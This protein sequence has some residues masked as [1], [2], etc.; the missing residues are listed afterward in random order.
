MYEKN[1]SQSS[2][3][4]QA[5]HFS[6]LSATTNTLNSRGSSGAPLNFELVAGLLDFFSFPAVPSFLPKNLLCLVLFFLGMF[7]LLLYSPISS[8]YLSITSKK[9]QPSHL[10]QQSFCSSSSLSSR[11]NSR[12]F[13]VRKEF[14]R[15]FYKTFLLSR[16]LGI[17]P[18]GG[19]TWIM[20]VFHFETQQRAILAAVRTKM[21]SKVRKKLPQPIEILTIILNLLSSKFWILVFRKHIRF[22]RSLN[23]F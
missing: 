23:I 7:F 14:L 21:L 13:P 8:S 20:T 5:S 10:S 12:F 19:I 22:H 2:W 17:A 4:I 18:Y 1:C 6:R 15:N 3:L 16:E 11:S 9:K